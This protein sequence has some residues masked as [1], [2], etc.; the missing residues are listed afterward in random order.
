MT[1]STIDN[2][3]LR[4]MKERLI[5]QFDYSPLPTISVPDA[6]RL[7]EGHVKVQ[8][9]VS[10]TR[11]LQKLY[12]SFN[13][14]CLSCHAINQMPGVRYTDGKPELYRAIREPKKCINCESESFEARCEY[15]NAIVVELR[16]I[17]TFSD[18]D[19][20]QTVLFD[21]DTKNAYAHIGEMA[22]VEGEI[23]VIDQL[24]TKRR[25]T[26]I[27]YLY[28]KSIKYESSQ[29]ITITKNDVE[30]IERFTR[31]KGSEILDILAAGMVAPEIIGYEDPKKGL[32]LCAASTGTDL[33]QKK[34]N[35]AFIGPPGLAKST[36]LRKA[37][38]LVPNSRYESGQNSS[39]K[40]L[41]AIVSS[42][43]E[44]YVLRTGP[45]VAAKGSICAINE[46]GRMNFEDQKH[47][48]D[49]MQ[50][51]FFTINK[52]G[53]SGT[54][55]SP[56]AIIA[57]ANPI[58]GEWENPDKIDLDEF[59]AI[60]P[61]IDRFDLIFPFRKKRDEIAVREYAD[62]KFDLDDKQ[63]PDYYAY[64]QKHIEYSKRFKPKL[65]EEAKFM[66]KE[67]YIDIAKSYGSPRVRETI[68]TIAKM[69]SRL[70]LKGVVDVED[71]KEA[72]LF[73]NKILKQLEG[74]VNVTTDPRDIAY[75]EC[76]SVLKE[77][78][79]FPLS[80]EEIIKSAC[81]RNEQVKRYIGD[82]YRFT[83]NHKLGPI[84]ELLLNNSQDHI[85]QISRRPIKLQWFDS[86][87]SNKS[88]DD[89]GNYT[90][91]NTNINGNSDGGGED[92]GSIS[93]SVSNNLLN[94]ANDVN[95]V[96]LSRSDENNLQGS[97]SNKDIK[98]QE[99][100][101]RTLEKSSQDQSLPMSYTSLTS[102]KPKE[103]QQNE[104]SHSIVGK[105]KCY[106]CNEANFPT[107]LDRIKHID[108]EHPGKLHHPTEDAFNNRLER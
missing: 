43:D 97:I 11:R 15:I 78:S 48:L 20:L 28:V 92:T 76:V 39:G 5:T 56:T 12:K 53:I 65:S 103:L 64:L 38:K 84:L 1:T 75:G 99:E 66:L 18:I 96:H 35:V 60:K 17:V 41:T 70:K 8:G 33:R 61:L 68:I 81:E 59:P 72:M 6:A 86:S 63:I 90:N 55:L 49:V 40:S 25:S 51:Q 34:V 73:Y 62:Q 13:Y 67:Y 107:D 57:S 87:V 31:Q 21:G 79:S 30:A 85:K 94:D 42:E 37:V 26:T 104:E 108:I 23:H 58:Y 77:S 105:L 27:S 82:K 2:E 101:N 52:Y 89:Q 80:F 50:E 9:M 100:S 98:S 24:H 88:K 14:E 29:E 16:D 32:L 36:L 106:Y 22:T 95:D 83:H 46:L 19:P 4:R 10:A 3:E 54:I 102:L 7:H 91:T 93:S 47:L 69:I 44:G 71:A 45:V 74:V